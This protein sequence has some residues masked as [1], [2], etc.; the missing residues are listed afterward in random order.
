M[1]HLQALK[2]SFKPLGGMRKP[3]ISKLL[4]KPATS[5]VL[6]DDDEPASTKTTTMRT[7]PGNAKISAPPAELED[8][9]DSDG[10]SND[11]IILA[12]I[13]AEDI[14]AEDAALTDTDAAEDAP[15][16][17][18]AEATQYRDPGADDKD[19]QDEEAEAQGAA[20]ANTP[21][22]KNTEVEEAGVVQSAL[23]PNELPN[24]PN[25]AVPIDN[26]YDEDLLP[27]IEDDE[28]DEPATIK[29]VVPES[30]IITP[31]EVQD[32]SATD[33]PQIE[34]CEQ[35]PAAALSTVVKTSRLKVTALKAKPLSKKKAISSG[36]TT[37]ALASTKPPKA[38]PQ[39]PKATVLKKPV[40][41]QPTVPNAKARPSSGKDGKKKK[42]KR[43][44]V[45]SDSE[46]DILANEVPSDSENDILVNEPSVAK[47]ITQRR[48]KQK[49]HASSK[50]T[51]KT[52][53]TDQVQQVQQ[54]KTYKGIERAKDSATAWTMKEPD[55]EDTPIPVLVSH[56]DVL[57]PG[58]VHAITEE[59][60][61]ALVT[62]DGFARRAPMLGVRPV[63]GSSEVYVVRQAS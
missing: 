24:E 37:A 32:H 21:N 56:Y 25:T 35:P 20:E 15:E 9:A 31:T 6:S 1:A 12:P 30:E 48:K 43:T 16:E 61:A 41:V 19:D 57:Y 40:K 49:R 39:L 22:K 23:L 50:S 58:K 44:E 34:E 54:G 53:D 29:Q 14:A 46:D 3:M 47:P 51:G 38:T 63:A 62:Y 27:N 52:R 60:D 59:E 42:K 45:P 13:V 33:L 2:K 55:D 7:I 5:K 8:Q 18:D 26:N 17:V 10:A 28:D 36:N 4:K 11:D